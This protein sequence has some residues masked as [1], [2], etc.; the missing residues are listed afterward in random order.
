M[1]RRPV[2]RLVLTT[3]FATALAN[4]LLFMGLI[5]M[6][7]FDLEDDI[8][9]DQVAAAADRLAEKDPR[10]LQEAG[11]V[12]ALD[13]QYYVGKDGM[14]DWIR[15]SEPVRTGADR[16]EL[17]AEDRGHF[18]LVAREL[19]GGERLYVLF[20][21]RPY[22]RST[23]QLAS[24][25]V[26][27][28]VTALLAFLVSL[29]FLRR[30]IAGISQ[31]L[32]QLS[33]QI[34]SRTGD[35]EAPYPTSEMAPAEIHLLA[36]AL[37]AREQRIAGLLERERAFNRDASHELRTPLAVALG[38][39]EIVED[40]S[41]VSKPLARL[42]NA[43]GDMQRLVDG[44]LWLAR[45]PQGNERCIALTIVRSSIAAHRH[46]LREQSV[47]VRDATSGQTVIPVPAEVALV[48]IGNLLRNA[49]AYSEGSDIAVEIGD[50][51]IAVHDGGSG[52]GRADRSAEGFGIGLSL[53][54]RL[55]DHFGVAVTLRARP[56]GGTEAVLQWEKPI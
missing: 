49:I 14:P 1:T 26:I 38:A 10:Q 42:K 34:A 24:Y 39:L 11:A 15:E 28:F 46:L 27:A 17:F 37:D 4:L 52:F 5:A 29:L 48:L 33:T 21:A 16:G 45:E 41:A 51:R 7:G 30:L 43:L 35:D 19:E 20:D 6:F 53:V 3:F 40:Q 47:A 31:P 54:R 12:A 25:L 50:D 18:H 36:Q 8:F 44:I 13:M 56:E 32:E 2:R 22:I 9:Q 23:P 55:G